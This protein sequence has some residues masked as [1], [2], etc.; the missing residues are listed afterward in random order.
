MSS[1]KSALI[2]SG[3]FQ[4]WSLEEFL[5]G[6]NCIPYYF[7]YRSG[8]FLLAAIAKSSKTWKYSSLQSTIQFSSSS[9][10]F[11]NLDDLFSCKMSESMML[12]NGSKNLHSWSIHL[13][14]QS[15]FLSE[16]YRISLTVCAI[17]YFLHFYP[18]PLHMVHNGIHQRTRMMI[19]KKWVTNKVTSEIKTKLQHVILPVTETNHIIADPV[20]SPTYGDR[21]WEHIV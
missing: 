4:S 14:P 9:S 21:R 2:S 12:A 10:L 1:K 6:K 17:D 5:E 18:F 7:C 19:V 13:G 15:I 8:F 16:R 11:G 20:N 3:I